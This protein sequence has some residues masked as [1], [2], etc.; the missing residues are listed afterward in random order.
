MD[1]GSV[2]LGYLLKNMSS[3]VKSGILAQ[4]IL[5]II[6][7]VVTY[8]LDLYPYLAGNPKNCLICCCVECTLLK[9]WSLVSVRNFEES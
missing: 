5:S 1:R 2:F 8:L 6:I 4:S 7:I 9:V 3:K